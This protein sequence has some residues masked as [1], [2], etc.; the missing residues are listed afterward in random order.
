MCERERERERETQEDSERQQEEGRAAGT[1]GPE[2]QQDGEF[3]GI[4]FCSYLRLGVEEAGSLQKPKSA[5]KKSTRKSLFSL[6]KVP[7]KG[8]LEEENA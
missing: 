8:N 3:S 2:G 4:S 5:D 6:A 1:S 7:G